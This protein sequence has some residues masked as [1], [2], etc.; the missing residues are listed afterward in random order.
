ME[1]LNALQEPCWGKCDKRDNGRK[2]RKGRIVFGIF[3]GICGV[4]G[5]LAIQQMPPLGVDWF[6]TYT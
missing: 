4:D 5:R 6:S 1:T 2:Q 3:G